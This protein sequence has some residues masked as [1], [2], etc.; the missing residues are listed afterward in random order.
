[1]VY[2]TFG[3]VCRKSVLEK[4]GFCFILFYFF[5]KQKL[6]WDFIFSIFYVLAWVN[7]QLFK[8]RMSAAASWPIPFTFI[9]V[10]FNNEENRAAKIGTT[11]PR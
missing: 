10:T 6:V 8:E 2:I 9:K 5:K 4:P 1:M 3:L 11:F 7:I